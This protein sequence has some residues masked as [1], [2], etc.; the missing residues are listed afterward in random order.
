ME[1]VIDAVEARVTFG[2]VV[3]ADVEADIY[4]D[5][6]SDIEF[7]AEEIEEENILMEEVL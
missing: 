2:A 6:L 4:A 3:E 5:I 1:K 7:S